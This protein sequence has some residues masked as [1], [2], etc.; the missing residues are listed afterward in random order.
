VNG[1]KNNNENNAQI[2]NTLFVT[3]LLLLLLLLIVIYDCDV[4]YEET[5]NS[6]LVCWSMMVSIYL[7]NLLSCLCPS[8]LLRKTTTLLFQAYTYDW[9]M[10]LIV[11][12]DGIMMVQM[13]WY[14]DDSVT[15]IPFVV[16]SLSVLYYV[17]CDE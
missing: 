1:R 4:T 13:I 11:L 8:I 6:G 16:M 10:L 9:M 17:G 14:T 5:N 7:L 15:T 12:Y 3:L 2:I